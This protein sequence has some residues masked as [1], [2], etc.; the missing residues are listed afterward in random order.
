MLKKRQWQC[1]NV[2]KGNVVK[3]ESGIVVSLIK[4]TVPDID[5]H[6]PQHHSSLLMQPRSMLR[7]VTNKSRQVD[8]VSSPQPP[9]EQLTP[10]RQSK[11]RRTTVH[12]PPVLSPPVLSPISPLVDMDSP[13]HHSS[14]L[15]Q[16]R[17]MLRDVTKSRQVCVCTLL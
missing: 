11:G 1:D 6:S 5:Q 8:T 4:N 14:L 7:D 15:I 13:Q 12:S 17:S 16:P 3:D 9:V 10:T 2:D